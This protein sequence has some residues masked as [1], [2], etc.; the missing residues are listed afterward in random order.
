MRAKDLAKFLAE[1]V[2]THRRAK[3]FSQ[4]ALAEAADIAPKMVS[5]IERRQRN[6]SVNLTD[7]IAQAMGVPLSRLIQEAEEM[8]QQTSRRK[9]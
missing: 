1:V 7:S 3:G 2:R 8:R 4:E 6:P 9:R 5:L